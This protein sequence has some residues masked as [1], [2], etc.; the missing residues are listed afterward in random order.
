MDLRHLDIPDTDVIQLGEGPDLLLLHTLLAERTVFD[1]VL[2]ELAAR[3]RLT[4]PNLPGYGDTPPLDQSSPSVLDYAD[5]IAGIMDAVG[6]PD[7]TGVLGNGAGGFVTVSVGIHHGDRCGKLILADTGPGF[8]DPAKTPLRILADKVE[9]NGMEAVLDAAMLRMFPEPYIA[10]NPDVIAER[11]AA[12]A[13]CVPAAFA[14]MARALANVE[15][16]DEL[17]A[18]TNETLVMVGLDDATTPPDLSYALHQ[19]IPG[20]ELIEIPDCGHCPQIQ[21]PDTFVSSVLDFLAA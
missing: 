18:I 15:M 16:A 4:V 6:L 13:T 3:H 11:K 10:A 20:A 17:G 7:D 14:A 2:P 9:A 19:G 12:L 21:A 8:P 5:W 1:R